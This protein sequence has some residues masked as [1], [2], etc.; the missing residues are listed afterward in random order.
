MA[1]IICTWPGRTVEPTHRYKPFDI[2]KARLT[3]YTHIL[4]AVGTKTDS[5]TLEA[6]IRLACECGARLTT[7]HVVD[8]MPSQ[9]LAADCN[10]GY[11]R[12]V[13]EA[14]GRELAAHNLAALRVAG[15]EGE[16]HTL[17][18]PMCGSTIGC[19]IAGHA[20]QIGAD[21]IMVGKPH[22]SWVSLFEEN[23]YKQVL[24]YAHVPVLIASDKMPAAAGRT[25]ALRQPMIETTGA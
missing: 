5:V 19:A 2:V 4:V 24:K 21:L 25:L 3:M 20:R 12:D 18:L 22:P 14:H 7:L 11:T 13:F 10:F 8:P 17:T 23:V 1:P 16:A 9:A 15:C 6:A